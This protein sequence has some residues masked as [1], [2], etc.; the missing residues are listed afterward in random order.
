MMK[1]ISAASLISHLPQPLHAEPCAIHFLIA[2]SYLRKFLIFRDTQHFYWLAQPSL[3]VPRDVITT[4]ASTIS[5]KRSE[6][7]ATGQ[8]ALP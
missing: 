2:A 8:F 5:D 1:N 4:L 3:R 7:A 6:M